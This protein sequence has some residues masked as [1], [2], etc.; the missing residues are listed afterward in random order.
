MAGDTAQAISR[1]S[2]RFEDLRTLFFEQ[3]AREVQAAGEGEGELTAI[4]DIC[5]LSLNF[6]SHEGILRAA[7][8]IVATLHRLFPGSVDVLDQERA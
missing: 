4:P 3:R 7:N 1:T 2:F 5:S 8:A 6:R